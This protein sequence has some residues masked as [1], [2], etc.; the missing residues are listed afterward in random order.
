MVANMVNSSDQ[1]DYIANVYNDDRRDDI[2]IP[3][4]QEEARETARAATQTSVCTVAI[5]ETQTK[6]SDFVISSGHI[7]RV[8]TATQCGCV[9]VRSVGTQTGPKLTLWGQIVNQFYKKPVVCHI[10]DLLIRQRTTL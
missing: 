2:R 9:S 10:F 5:S 4:A 3:P 1:I 7:S 6:L 8:S